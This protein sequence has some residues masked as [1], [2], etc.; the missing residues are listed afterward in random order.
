MATVNEHGKPSDG[1]CCLCTMEDITEKL[2]NYV[3]YQCYPSMKWKSSFFEECVVQQ[4]LDSQYQQYIDRVKKTDCQA[5]LRRL[6]EPGPPIH[7]SDKHGFPLSEDDGD[8]RVAK[9]W[10]ASD[11][12]ERNAKLADALEGKERD[13]LWKE[14][15]NFLLDNTEKEVNTSDTRI[16]T[17]KNSE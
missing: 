3:E 13:K 1:M 7:I 2:Q 6:L 16:S 15:R 11:G 10:Y 9:L 4:L 5:E 14:L 8:L 17:E 12:K